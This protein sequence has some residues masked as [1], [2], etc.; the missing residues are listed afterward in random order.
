[1]TARPT[2]AVVVP[3]YEAEATVAVAVGSAL[4]QT[5]RP[6]QVIVVDDGSTDATATR[7]R[8]VAPG[9]VTVVSTPNRGVAAARNE[10]LA[11]A[12][13]DYVAF[14]DADDY[15]YPLKLEA[16]LTAI[17]RLPVRSVAATAAAD[18][19]QAD[20][21]RVG[22][23]P[24]EQCRDL[25]TGLLLGSMIAGPVSSLVVSREAAV[26]IG[27]FDER[28]SQCA[29]WDFFLRLSLHTSFAVV[30]QPLLAYHTGSDRMSSDIALLERDTF[31]VL[32]AFFAQTPT[33][34]ATRRRAYGRHWM[35]VAGSYWHAGKP[36]EALRC[37]MRGVAADPVALRHPVALPLR[38]ARRARRARA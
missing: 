3:A 20:G 27:G 36:R 7:A 38:R 9:R 22:R 8:L 2:V 33:P 24:A 16:Q 10:G 13:T 15:W 21:S 6:N 18:R 14:L 28:F 12:R 5:V 29:D 31:A 17:D 11:H 26:A 35:I 30:S 25:T 37:A 23:F 19:V 4:D 32:D 1:M 34:A